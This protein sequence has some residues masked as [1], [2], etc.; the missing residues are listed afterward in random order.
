MI[1]QH[2]I[3]K[4][5]VD[6]YQ[7]GIEN[8]ILQKIWHLRKL[9]NVNGFIEQSPQ[10]TLDVGCA[11]G[12]FI[13]KIKERFPDSKFYGVDI[14]N[15][16]IEYAKKLYSGI[17]FRSADAHF[18]PYDDNF[19]DLVICTEVI[20]HLDDPQK[21]IK[22]MKRVLKKSGKLI[23]E[24]DSGSLLF[25]FVWFFWTKLRGKVWN[26]S[27]LHSFN[28]TKLEDFAE[29]NELKVLKKK[30][31]NLGMAMIFLLEK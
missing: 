8:N 15:E 21:A 30:K 6:Y 12:W 19:F 13:A 3:E 24:V 17:E 23:I 5:P 2:I 1:H 11:S 18:L 14:Y 22:E 10:K 26:D 31:F 9:D 28:I 20:E 27:H 7:Y 29:K 4:V 16:S 25:S